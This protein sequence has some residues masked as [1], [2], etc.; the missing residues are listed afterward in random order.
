MHFFIYYINA[1]HLEHH[2]VDHK[3][4]AILLQMLHCLVNIGCCRHWG[5][6][7]AQLFSENLP[8]TELGKFFWITI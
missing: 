7:C 8:G 5:S 6:V 3:S 4:F 2:E 1:R